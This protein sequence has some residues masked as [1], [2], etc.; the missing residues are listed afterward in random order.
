MT[1]AGKRILVLSDTHGDLSVAARL[2]TLCPSPDALLHLGDFAD[3]AAGI[4][5]VLGCPYHAVR[6][7]CDYRALEPQ[8]RVITLFGKRFLLTHGHRY[9]SELAL[10]LSGEQA[11]CDAVLFGHTHQPLLTAHG[12]V[13]IIN[14][15]SP[16]YPRGG[17]PA[18]C[19][20][21]LIEGNELHVRMLKV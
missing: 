8:E 16:V 4:A 17:S 2:I 14:P 18:S 20:L 9:Q 15:G 10:G 6:G 1:D 21:L 11:R 19:A 12:S 13:L 3:D 5:Q 7:N